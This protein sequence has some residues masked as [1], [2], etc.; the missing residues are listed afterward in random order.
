[1]FEFC[2]FSIFSYFLGVV[3][4]T[5]ARNFTGVLLFVGD[6]TQLDLAE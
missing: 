2:F 4:G 1:V 6:T 5:L 3:V